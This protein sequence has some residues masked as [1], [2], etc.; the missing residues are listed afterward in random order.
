MGW[1]RS[2]QVRANVHDLAHRAAPVSCG[3][4]ATSAGKNKGA[5]GQT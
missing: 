3:A 2:E 5:E 1:Q 4:G